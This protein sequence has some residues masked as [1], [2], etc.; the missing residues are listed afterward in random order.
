MRWFLVFILCAE[1]SLD[2]VRTPALGANAAVSAVVFREGDVENVRVGRSRQA[3]GVAPH[4]WVL[5]KP[6]WAGMSWQGLGWQ[7][8]SLFA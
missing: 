7:I 2:S 6:R 3:L 8:L 4:R 5:R 1:M